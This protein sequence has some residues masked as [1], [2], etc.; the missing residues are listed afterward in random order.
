DQR[1]R[2]EPPLD[3]DSERQRDVHRTASWCHVELSHATA[4]EPNVYVAARYRQTGRSSFTKI[5]QRKGMS[6]GRTCAWLRY[7]RYVIRR[8]RFLLHRHCRR[9][10]PKSAVACIGKYSQRRQRSIPR[11]CS[12]AK[13]QR[14]RTSRS[15]TG[16]ISWCREI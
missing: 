14:L 4:F 9:P 1:R 2:N 10:R 13:G 12:Y 5:F 8:T 7:R 6:C 16:Q 15:V 11:A 3:R